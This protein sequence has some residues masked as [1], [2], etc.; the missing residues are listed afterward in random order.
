MNAQIS[1]MFYHQGGVIVRFQIDN[2]YLEEQHFNLKM[3]ITEVN[4]TT[5]QK[6]ISL[7]A[8]KQLADVFRQFHD[9]LIEHHDSGISRLPWSSS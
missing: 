8:A 7:T 3:P 1:S 5:D 6:E 4:D 2:P 9:A